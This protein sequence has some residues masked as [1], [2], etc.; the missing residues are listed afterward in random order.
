MAGYLPKVSA[1]QLYREPSLLSEAMLRIEKLKQK[2]AEA[3]GPSDEIRVFSAPG[4]TEIG[5]NHT[6]HQQGCVLAAAVSLDA[7][8]VAAPN[9]KGVIY[10]Y[11]EGYRD[12]VVSLDSLRPRA[13]EQGNSAAMVRG[14]VEHLNSKGFP[15]GGFNCVIMNQVPGGSGLS[16]SA[17]FEVLI[18]TV[19][20]GIFN[21]GSI[22]PLEIAKAGQYAENKHFGK[23]SGLMDQTAS[24]VGGVSS[25]DFEVP[26]SP[27]VEQVL[28]DF[29]KYG[30]A[31]CVIDTGV[32][33]HDLVDA[34]A[35]IPSEMHTVAAYFGKSKLREVSKSDFYKALPLM[36]GRIPHRALLRAMHFFDDS[37]RALLEAQ[38][39]REGDIDRFLALIN[40]SGRSSW[41]LLQN[42]YPDDAGTEQP[43][44]LALACCNYLLGGK[45]A[46]RIHGGGFAGTIQ[47]FVPLEILDGF[48]GDIE[49]VTGEG[50]CK[51]L[52]IRDIGASEIIGFM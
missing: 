38:A 12:V 24:A 52:S 40:E 14:V 15:V 31:L 44:A 43:A 45:G 47:A 5:G 37:N 41:M 25:I 1:Q 18:G 46:C 22:A 17:A 23:P 8:A 21:D 10:V 16:S 29:S 33:H 11:S 3:F 51:V 20:N 13:E 39:L 2:Y 27:K 35:S 28:F 6:D 19:I 50:S 34:Y 49:N 32:Y 26:D 42:I 9:D 7:L 48:R 4:R 30:Y 36:A